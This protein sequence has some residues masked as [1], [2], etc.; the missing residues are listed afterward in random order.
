MGWKQRI[1]PS[2][3]PE[4]HTPAHVSTASTRASAAFGLLV[5][6][7]EHTEPINYLPTDQQLDQMLRSRLV[8]ITG[9]SGSGKSCLLR[10]I[11]KILNQRSQSRVHQTSSNTD[12]KELI[13]ASISILDLFDGP[14]HERVQSLSFAGLADPKLWPMPFSTLST[15]QQSRVILALSMHRSEQD[16]PLLSDEFCTTIDRTT[17]YAIARTTHRWS[18]SRSAP[19]IVATAHEDMESMLDPDHVFDM[20]TMN[21]RKPDRFIAQRIRIEQGNIDDYRQLAHLHYRADF[22][23]TSAQIFRAVRTTPSSGEILAGVL[24]VSHPTLNSS[25]RQYAWN[26]YFTT[27]NKSLNAQRINKDLRCI[28]RVIVESR[29]RGLGV[30]TKLVRHYLS[31][32]LTRATESVA[33]MGSVNPFF[34]RAGMVAY[35]VMPSLADLRLLDAINCDNLSAADLINH[36]PSPGSL[37]YRELVT[38]GKSRKLIAS[39]TPQ[40]SL[41]HQIAPIA[42][43]RLINTPRAYAHSHS[44]NPERTHETHEQEY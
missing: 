14:L 3:L 42:A 41:V 22:P 31:S 15:G 9:P 12:Y 2:S 27:K 33:M 11:A 25:W 37:V 7:C 8:L 38:W 21:L 30:A 39:G 26:G 19:V 6:R 4:L 16:E 1:S 36:I 24:V 34:E 13:D 32:S 20:H 23:A 10:G 28:S 40:P 43:C 29:S 44:M 17:A 5:R 18:R 35:T